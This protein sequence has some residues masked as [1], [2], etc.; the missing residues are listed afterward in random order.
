MRP[1]VALIALGLAAALAAQ[2]G[3]YETPKA[4]PPDPAQLQR[5]LE[6]VGTLLARSSAARQIE[7]SG[8]P[9]ARALRDQA[10]AL[11]AKA[12]AAMSAGDLA[13]AAELLDQAVREMFQ[14]VKLAAPEQLS[15]AKQRSDFDAR[16]ESVKVLLE[17]QRRIGR[18]KAAAEA[19]EISRR[20]EQLLQ[21]ASAQAAAGNLD[22]ARATLDQAYLSAKA[23]IGG[24]RQ[25]DTLVRTLDFA[26]KED[27]Y[28]YELDR[29]DTH[30][31]LIKLLLDEKRQSGSTD[32]MVQGHQERAS[33][34]RRQAEAM[35]DKKDF[36]GAVRLL[37]ESTGELVRAI[38]GAG[39][40][41][42]G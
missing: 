25:G 11:H 41:I 39:I 24:M 23:A 35:A 21:E 13:A 15:Q 33:A 9:Q 22:R 36:A 14:G 12:A 40:Y 7:A 16:L 1:A 5:R 42:P 2:A 20:I 27:E 18:E 17:A 37:E 28:R 4:P 30:Q 31:M 34:L 6:S 26:S 29:N 32:R 19:A 10:R 38:R 3:Q 8:S